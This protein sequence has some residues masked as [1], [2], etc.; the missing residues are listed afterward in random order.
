MLSILKRSHHK[1]EVN[2][3]LVN[4]LNRV[5]PYTHRRIPE[6][7]VLFLVLVCRDC[8]AGLA[9]KVAAIGKDREVVA[10]KVSV[11]N[12]GVVVAKKVAAIG[13]DRESVAKKVAVINKGVVVAKKVAAIGKD[14]ESV[15]KKVAVINKG[16]VVAKKVAA[17]NKGVVAAKKVA[18]ICKGVVVAKKLAVINK[19]IGMETTITRLATMVWMLLVHP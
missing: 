11:I 4:T 19:G 13:K 3:P 17:I 15:A 5:D 16:V 12:K 2:H 1:T 18:A 8:R 6:L 7:L 9:K 10:K 14:R